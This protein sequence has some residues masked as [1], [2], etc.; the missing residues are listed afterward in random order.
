MIFGHLIKYLPLSDC[1]KAALDQPFLNQND[2]RSK[3]D[4]FLCG[5]ECNSSSDNIQMEEGLCKNEI[6]PN[7]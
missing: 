6:E 2:N 7:R 1:F 3:C 4:G 5:K